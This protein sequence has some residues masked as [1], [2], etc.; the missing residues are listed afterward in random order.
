M[1]ICTKCSKGRQKTD[2]HHYSRNQ[3]PGK[4]YRSTICKK[5]VTQ[6]RKVWRENNREQDR[7]NNV[8]KKRRKKLKALNMTEED[9]KK[10]YNSQSGVCAI[11]SDTDSK[12][13]CVDHDHKSGKVRGLLCGSCNLALGCLRDNIL[14]VESAGQYLSLHE[15]VDN[16]S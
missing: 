14:L 12:S 10:L 4:V 11:C 9:Y 6:Q 3:Y 1:I 7:K 13:L 15:G 8:I 2:Y 5:C 16:D